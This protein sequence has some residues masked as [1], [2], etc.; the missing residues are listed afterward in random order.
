MVLAGIMFVLGFIKYDFVN[1]YTE[2]DDFAL[3]IR[4]SGKYR[5]TREREVNYLIEIIEGVNSRSDRESSKPKLGLHCVYRS[6]F[7]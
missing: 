2:K 5:Q 6:D 3:Q 4:L 1:F 7:Y